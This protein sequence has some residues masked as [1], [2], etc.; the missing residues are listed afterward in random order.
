MKRKQCEITKRNMIDAILSRCTIGRMATIGKDGYPYITPVNY[1]YLNDTIYF[2]CA[3][4]G[5]KLENINRD[6]RVCFEVDIPLAYL[7]L[8]YYGELPEACM[9]HQFYHS[10]IIRGKADR[11]TNLEEKLRAL[12][13]LVKSHEPTGREFIP[14]TSD[15]PAVKLCEVVAVRIESI[16]GKSDLAQKKKP[17]EKKKLATY[18][19]NRNLPGDT[20]AAHL[21]LDDTH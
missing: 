12:N 13:G 6:P 21:I 7:D 17:E 11:V 9:V 18:L 19:L 1:V 14:I 16:T 4:A 10:V 3:S 2:H 15:T 8:D 20:E 5:E